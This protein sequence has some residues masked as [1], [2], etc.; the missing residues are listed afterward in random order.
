[1]S[2]TELLLEQSLIHLHTICGY[3]HTTETIWPT[4]PEIFTIWP[5][6]ENF[7][8]PWASTTS[9]IISRSSKNRYPSLINTQFLII[10]R[11]NG[12]E[13]WIG[14]SYLVHTEIINS[15]LT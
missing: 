3:F 11:K 4:K 13:P 7:S 12:C 10:Y 2:I 5:F 8:D 14:N 6:L 15:R 9:T 1:M